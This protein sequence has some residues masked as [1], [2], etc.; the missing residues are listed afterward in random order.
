[1]ALEGGSPIFRASLDHCNPAFCMESLR[2][3]PD[4]HIKTQ[5][6]L[7]AGLCPVYFPSGSRQAGLLTLPC[8]HLSRKSGLVDECLQGSLP[9][10][11]CLS[12]K[13]PRAGHYKPPEVCLSLSAESETINFIIQDLILISASSSLA[14]GLR[15]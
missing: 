10:E 3:L 1:M 5:R 13:A 15:G 4:C 7:R 8:C 14:M 12:Q 9:E 11:M 2:L 6:A